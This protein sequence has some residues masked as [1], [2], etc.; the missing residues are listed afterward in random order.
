MSL[1]TRDLNDGAI[2]AATTQTRNDNESIRFSYV[3]PSGRKMCSEWISPD[4]RRKAM[5]AWLDAVKA[6]I[7]EDVDKLRREK[8]A[9]ARA[10]QTVQDV[11]P[12]G[13]VLQ[14]YP[15][16]V[17]NSDPGEY[18]SAQLEA[19]RED[20]RILTEQRAQLL[21]ALE[22]AEGRLNKWTTIHTA[23]SGKQE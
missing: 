21:V 15:I 19:A 10:A 14:N 2:L 4:N 7:V 17:A 9:S 16:Q 12:A 20:V 6:A 22:S 23:L 13:T 8:A 18:A 11:V 1:E 5:G 3:L